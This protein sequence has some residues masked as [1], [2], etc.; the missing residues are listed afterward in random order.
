MFKHTMHD[1]RPMLASVALTCFLLLALLSVGVLTFL[2]T[3]SSPAR[4][5]GAHRHAGSTLFYMG[6]G[7]SLAFGFQPNGD[8]T[9]GYVQ[10]LFSIFK[11]DSEVPFGLLDL[12]CPGETSTTMI[13]GGCPSAP[14]KTP[15]QLTLAL[16]FLAA[17][18]RQVP[19]IT[20]DIGANDVLGDTNPV[21]CAVNVA[22]FNAHL[23]TLDFN[24]TH[25]ILPQ[26][27]AALHSGVIVMMNYYDPFQ[28]ICPNTVP[29]TQTENQHLAADVRGFGSIVDVFSAFGGARVPNP[30]IC[31]FTW[32]CT[33]FVNI[34][35]TTLGY[36]VITLTF[37]A[38]LFGGRE[39]I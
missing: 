28:N 8:F 22:T 30:N 37:A 12:G 7:N 23:A 35:P 10:D 9:H 1:R 26:L 33:S 34:H 38:D 25:I 3:K 13:K 21:T 39:E 6:L 36:S 5:T 19:F 15:A 24:L 4:A 29:F 31:R 14:P 27:H 11:N 32:M 18:P 17:H 20:L 2:S 16:A